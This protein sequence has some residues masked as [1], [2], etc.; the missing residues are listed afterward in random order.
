MKLDAPT[1][2]SEAA[3]TL[4]AQHQAEDE[5]IASA[6]DNTSPQSILLGQANVAAFTAEEADYCSDCSDS[7]RG[8]EYDHVKE[9]HLGC[10]EEYLAASR[11]VEVAQVAKA[12][13]LATGTP[14]SASPA[15]SKLNYSTSMPHRVVI[16]SSP[17]VAASNERVESEP[18]N[19]MP[20]PR[21]TR[22]CSNTLLAI[23]NDTFN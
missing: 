2:D 3:A 12:V 11:S 9:A 16:S 15:F 14:S 19:A 1:P 13:P 20:L 23:L 7:D 4:T 10:L 6:L 22:R 18:T 8:D 17:Q 5:A 21:S